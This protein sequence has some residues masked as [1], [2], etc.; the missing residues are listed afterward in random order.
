MTDFIGYMPPTEVVDAK[1]FAAYCQQEIGTPYPTTKSIAALRRNIKG[2]FTQYPQANYTTLCKIVDWAKARD[3][4]V[5]NSHNLV[6]M[7]RYAWKDGFL[8]ELTPGKQTVDVDLE[9]KITK[10]LESETLPFWR[11]RLEG[12]EGVKA[13]TLVFSSWEE[14]KAKTNA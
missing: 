14:W 13:R 7:F 2:L 11:Q 9:T 5:A 4:R 1:S 12:A 3:K 8:P 10:A 6:M